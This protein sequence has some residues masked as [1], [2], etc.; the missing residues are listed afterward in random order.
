MK[1]LTVVLKAM[2]L[3]GV[4]FAFVACGGGGAKSGDAKSGGAGGT[5]ALAKE[6]CKCEKEKDEAKQE[7]CFETIIA[8]VDKLSDEDRKKLEEAYE[9]VCK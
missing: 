5:D 4:V 7:K 2:M 1:R 9:K 6:I 3:A 8:K